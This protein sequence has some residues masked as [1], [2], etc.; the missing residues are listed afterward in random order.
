MRTFTHRLV[1]RMSPAVILLFLAGCNDFA[2]AVRTVTYP[3]DFTYVSSDEL[4]SRMQALA[5]QLQQLDLVLASGQGE[6]PE[7]ML[8]IQQNVVDRLR[9][10]ERIGGTLQAGEAGSN[11]PFLQDDMATFLANVTQAR[12]AA[13]LN[14]PRYY[15]AGRISGG[16][17]NCHRVNR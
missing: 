2:A 14:P 17:A 13:S 12:L 6:A 4:Q 1:L 9:A 8:E 3:P 10:I 7:L 5:Y 16:C 15:L 11:H